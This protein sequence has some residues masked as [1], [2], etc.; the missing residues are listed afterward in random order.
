MEPGEYFV[1]VTDS[2]GCSFTNDKEYVIAPAKAMDFGLVNIPALDC[3]NYKRAIKIMTA[4]GR[5]PI[6][7]AGNSPLGGSESY[8]F[9]WSGTSAITRVTDAQDPMTVTTV[10]GNF[11][12]HQG[13]IYNITKGGTYKV[14]VTDA[15]GCK[16]SKEI[17][18]PVE[19]EV[20]NV[21][22]SSSKLLR[23]S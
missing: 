3:D 14:T 7:G 9:S 11:D 19:I 21:Y 12:L 13:D 15:N 6:Y 16:L 8:K 20:E 22:L 1:T 23:W 4:D 10:N 18:V 2:E 17:S 5:E